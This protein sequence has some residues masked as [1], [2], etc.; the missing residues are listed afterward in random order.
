MI[1]E[2]LYM[3]VEEPTNSYIKQ[4][5]WNMAIGLNKVDNLTPSKYL[6]KLSDDNINNKINTNEIEELIK[7]HYDNQDS[8]TI[9][10]NEFECDLV[11]TRIVEL[12]NERNFSFRPTTLKV[13]HNYLFKD[14]YD[15]S[16]KYRDYNITKKE[17]ILN[18][19][20]VIYSSYNEI[21]T[22]L[23]YDFNK[24]LEYD[25]SKIPLNKQIVHIAEFT[26]RIWQVHPFGEG[27]TRTIA[28]MI[29]KYLRS[30]GYNVNNDLFKKYSVYFRNALVR[31]NYSNRSKDIYPTNEYLIMFFENLLT[32]KNHNLENENLIIKELF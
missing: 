7:K 2:S 19:D 24:E 27:N 18:N 32:N 29:E 15:F 13:I 23:E 6:L 4:L 28:V 16:G 14:I 25:Y 21:E 11:S 26:S 17:E 20:T 8:N 10:K 31:S 22:T 12:L 9:N 30:L 5:Y 1:D 3:R